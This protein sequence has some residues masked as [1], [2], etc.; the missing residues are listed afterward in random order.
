MLQ[1]TCPSSV[2]LGA[3]KKEHPAS[4]F[5]PFRSSELLRILLYTMHYAE[6]H[7]DCLHQWELLPIWLI[8]GA[9]GPFSENRNRGKGG[10]RREKVE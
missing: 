2:Q 4:H 9:G 6:S 8:L 3:P 7:H 5:S 10:E 1:L